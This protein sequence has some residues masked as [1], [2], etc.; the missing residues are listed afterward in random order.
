MWW[1]ALFQ[2]VCFWR[3]EIEQK[4]KNNFWTIIYRK[5]KQLF[6]S[7]RNLSKSTEPAVF[8]LGLYRRYHCGSCSR[9]DPLG[10]LGLASG[11]A[12]FEAFRARCCCSLCCYCC[13]CR[14][15]LAW[16]ASWMRW[17]EETERRSGPVSTRAAT[18]PALLDR[19]D[20]EGA[21]GGRRR[22]RLVGSKDRRSWWGCWKVLEVDKASRRCTAGLRR[23]AERPHNFPPRPTTPGPL[24]SVASISFCNDWK[25][26]V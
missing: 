10:F 18:F 2:V 9:I 13:Y 14:S 19:V 21:S 16:T 5:F 20:M 26:L 6:R 24:Q 23:A 15:C 25:T 7:Q 4:P 1:W 8:K 12:I 11:S 22:P 17:D 3:D